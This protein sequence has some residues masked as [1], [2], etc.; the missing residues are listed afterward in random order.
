MINCDYCVLND[1]QRKILLK[2]M[3]DSMKDNGYIFMDVCS[4]QMYKK[5]EEDTTFE[6]VEKDGFWS[7]QH[8]YVFK[9]IFKYELN[10]VTLDKYTI[11]EK[12]RSMEIFNWLKHFSIAELR[13]EF[14]ESGLEILEIYSDVKGKPFCD[15]SDIIA[16]ILGKK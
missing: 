13:R 12:D 7:A 4:D 6:S 1:E 2:I 14:E 15:D 10:H 5:I 16:L 3:K 11:F 9:S 8:H